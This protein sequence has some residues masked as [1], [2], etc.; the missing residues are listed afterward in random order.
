MDRLL[1][2]LAVALACGA[3]P[4]FAAEPRLPMP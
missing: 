4:A 3:A 2:P 1:Y